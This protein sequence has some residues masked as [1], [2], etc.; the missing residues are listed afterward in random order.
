M[1]HVSD[2]YPTKAA[3]SDRPVNKRAPSDH[4]RLRPA[5]EPDI[6]FIHALMREMAVFEKLTEIFKATQDSLR[7]S[8]F[9]PQP[10]AHCL[11]IHSDAEPDRPIA[12]IMWFYNYSSFLDKRGLYLEDIYVQPEHRGRGL[13]S[14]A[15]RHLAQLAV[16]QDCGR[17]EWTVLDWNQNAIDFYKRHGA[18]ILPEWRI[19]RVTGDALQRLAKES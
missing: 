10:A 3:H 4:Y 2:S 7:A 19:V 5:R 6:P 17:F 18:E 15:L 8:F 13:G 9:G 1:K 11:V 16:E 14:M 12:Y